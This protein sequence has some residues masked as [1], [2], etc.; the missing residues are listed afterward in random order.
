MREVVVIE[1]VTL[2]GVMQAPAVPR[3]TTAAGSI[4][5]AEACTQTR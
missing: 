5:A 1:H 4:T 2:D 3:R